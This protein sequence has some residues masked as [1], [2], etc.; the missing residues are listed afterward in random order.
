MRGES[1]DSEDPQHLQ[2][3]LQST[4][5]IFLWSNMVASNC[6]GFKLTR[7]GDPL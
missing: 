6:W 3:N 7:F 5:D 1:E 4:V 2:T